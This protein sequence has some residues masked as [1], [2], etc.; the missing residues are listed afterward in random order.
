MG[1]GTK[2]LLLVAALAAVLLWP[3]RDAEAYTCSYGTY[4]YSPFASAAQVAMERGDY[5]AVSGGQLV[6]WFTAARG[7]LA[8]ESWT[9]STEAVQ[10][11]EDIAAGEPLSLLQGEATVRLVR[12]LN[13]PINWFA[14][15]IWTA[16]E[17]IGP[18]TEHRVRFDLPNATPFTVRFD[19]ELEEVDEEAVAA[20]LSRTVIEV[21]RD[22]VST[23]YEK[24]CC[25]IRQHIPCRAA[26]REVVE[27]S[28]RGRVTAALPLATVIPDWDVPAALPSF[29][30]SVEFPHEGN[31][32]EP[33]RG[34]RLLRLQETGT[35]G[36]RHNIIGPG[37]R[38]TQPLSVV[39][40]EVCLRAIR[41]PMADEDPVPV[42]EPLCMTL[43][44]PDTDIKWHIHTRSGGD[45]CQGID[46][47]G[48]QFYDDWYD[49]AVERENNCLDEGTGLCSVLP[50]EP[51][52]PP[53]PDESFPEST[54]E[55][56]SDP[57]TDPNAD[58]NTDPN[59]DPDTDPDTDRGGK[60]GSG[61]AV[62][63][64]PGGPVGLAILGLAF[65]GLRRR[66]SA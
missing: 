53:V 17:E 43:E 28:C 49:P 21:S 20:W 46:P 12:P 55:G 65:L 31:E 3:A 63:N 59:T 38:I 35:P 64:A 61:C 36:H 42:G 58:P 39:R 33:R 8:Y 51:E 32:F 7:S 56:E 19:A 37:Q 52:W 23:V 29:A 40:P 22:D 13:A 5:L 27:A 54:D 15:M 66:D 14:V 48:G 18:D 6:V 47:T 57:N 30:V 10:V 11:T 4:F 60:D 2:G 50:E 9:H 26:R 1:N 16:E 62:S 24:D 25:I 34:H 41:I 44:V 45:E